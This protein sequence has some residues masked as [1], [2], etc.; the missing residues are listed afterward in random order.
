[1][2]IYEKVFLKYQARAW[3]LSVC[4]TSG[5]AFYFYSKKKKKKNITQEKMTVS[6][7]IICL[8]D[9]A[10]ITR[11]MQGFLHCVWPPGMDF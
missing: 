7:K 11:P 2:T 3:F 1:M 10:K 9:F 4:L 8:E 6:G 5:N